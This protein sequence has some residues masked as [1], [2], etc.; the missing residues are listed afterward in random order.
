LAITQISKIQVRR[1]HL[2]D[3]PKPLSSAE[4]GWAIDARRLYIGNGE[5]SE[6]APLIGNTEIL[7]E[8][9]DITRLSGMYTFSG[10]F[11]AGYTVQTGD[12]LSIISRSLGDKLDD[13]ANF[14]DFGGVGDGVTNEVK[15]FNR[16]IQQLNKTSVLNIEARV[17]RTLHIPAGVYVLGDVT[18]SSNG[19]SE[20]YIK[21]LPF[22]KLR[23]DGKNSTFII[24]V[25]ANAPCVVGNTDTTLQTY[26]VD[27]GAIPH[28]GYNEIE[29]ITLINVTANHIARFSTATDTLL[30]QVRMQH[31]I[32]NTTLPVPVVT[33][34][35]TVSFEVDI[36]APGGDMLKTSCI[37]L[38]GTDTT[39]QSQLTFQ[40]CEFIGTTTALTSESGSVATILFDNC[41]FS[42]LYRGLFASQGAVKVVSSRFA[43]IS[44]EAIY[45]PSGIYSVV[46]AYN[47]FTNVGNALTAT[48][49]YAILDLWG[50]NSYSIGDTF[51][52][53]LTAA[54]PAINLR[55][56]ASFATLP[57][58]KMML[59]K[60]HSAGGQAYTLPDNSTAVVAGVVGFGNNPTKLE[61]TIQRGV[62]QRTGTMHIAPVGTALVYSD[63]YVETD[64]LLVTLVPILNG[65]VVELTYTTAPITL[66]SAV[67]ATLT[68]ASRT[69][70]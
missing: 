14:R 35:A 61:Y 43:D 38:S 27:Q 4:M 26:V 66:L 17:R 18:N 16:A 32:W 48:P 51:D 65:S 29:G 47:T 68:V 40:N 5:Q 49:V 21:L 53:S 67:D 22:V 30:S 33:D 57:G 60:Q 64:D 20:D 55:G 54:V 50:D 25:N 13:I 12:G 7:T 10:K 59:G 1:G 28:P 63:D 6:G 36:V 24:Q 8:H 44:H 56:K 62:E 23:G 42:K 69:L 34:S 37:A 11:A 45:S 46:S 2:E 39:L 9:S 15:A 41:F 58:G 3:L 70:T 52:R 31:T 19:T